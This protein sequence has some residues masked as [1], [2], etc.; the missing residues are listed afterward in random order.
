MAKII[1][2][3]PLRKFTGNAA[4]F[5]TKGNTIKEAIQEL[6]DSHPNL[7]RHIL[8]DNNNIRSFIR[9]YLEENDIN[10]LQKEETL[11]TENQTISIV[12]AIAGGAK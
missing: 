8:D 4:T 7:N 9:I 6:I 5:E 2:P 1:I 3:T 10:S 11:V 12:P